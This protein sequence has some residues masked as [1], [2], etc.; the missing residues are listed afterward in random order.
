MSQKNNGLNQQMEATMG[1]ILRG[2]LSSAAQQNPQAANM[3]AQPGSANLDI[4]E[5]AQQCVTRGDT[6]SASIVNVGYGLLNYFATKKPEVKLPASGDMTIE[7]LFTYLDAVRTSDIELSNRDKL[8]EIFQPVA[9]AF[10]SALIHNM[11]N[12]QQQQPIV[13]YM[14]PQSAV[15]MLPQLPASPGMA[16]QIDPRTPG[17]STGMTTRLSLRDL[18]AAR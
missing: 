2:L 12:K 16:T 9:L 15:G 17:L 1:S 8:F 3:F 4:E 14:Q 7:N 5:F 11:F 18:L 10:G 6:M 13:I